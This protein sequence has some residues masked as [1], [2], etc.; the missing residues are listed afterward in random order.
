MYHHHS[1][2]L[3]SV[4]MYILVP[5]TQ[6]KRKPAS[7]QPHEQ[8]KIPLHILAS[9]VTIPHFQDIQ[10]APISPHQDL[11]DPTKYVETQAK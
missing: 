7:N 9:S 2:I 11:S 8:I 1:P 3:E 6:Y 10:P 5:K 4:D